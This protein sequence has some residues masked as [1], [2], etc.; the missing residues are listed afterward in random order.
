MRRNDEAR[1]RPESEP[2]H[3]TNQ[4]QSSSGPRQIRGTYR[5]SETPWAEAWVLLERETIESATALKIAT[6]TR[7]TLKVP[8]GHTETLRM[9]RLNAAVDRCIRSRVA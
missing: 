4:D 5:F 9:A 6:L 1:P 3:K 2:A 7:L 8:P